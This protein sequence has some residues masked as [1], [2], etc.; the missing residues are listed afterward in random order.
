MSNFVIS[1][2]FGIA[3]RIFC[4]IWFSS[5]LSSISELVFMDL[6]LWRRCCIFGSGWVLFWLLDVQFWM[7][8]LKAWASFKKDK[9]DLWYL[10]NKQLGRCRSEEKEARE[11]WWK[12]LIVL[13]WELHEKGYVLDFH[14]CSCDLSIEIDDDD[15]WYRCPDDGTVAVNACP[16]SAEIHSWHQKY[17]DGMIIPLRFLSHFFS[18]INVICL[19][20]W[21]LVVADD[22]VLHFVMLMVYGLTSSLFLFSPCFRLLRFQHLKLESMVMLSVTLLGLISS[23]ARSLRILSHPPTTVMYNFLIL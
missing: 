8:W 2:I 1:N 10:L 21:Y 15:E 23:T 12:G 14:L 22:E 13:A 18:L 19:C 16:V 20:F 11:E 6:V 7:D 9:I 4:V 5:S 3:F 17:W